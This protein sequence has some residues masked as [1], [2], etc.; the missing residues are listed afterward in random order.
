MNLSKIINEQTQGVT[1]FTV[2]SKKGVCEMGVSKHQ[3]LDKRMSVLHFDGKKWLIGVQV[4]SLLQRETYNLYRSLKIKGIY[5]KRATADQIEWLFKANVV[6]PGTRSVTF[7][8]FDPTLSFILEEAKKLSR[9][10]R[11][12]EASKKQQHLI[13]ESDGEDSPEIHR[14]PS[15]PIANSYTS[16]HHQGG[17]AGVIAGFPSIHESRPSLFPNNEESAQFN[18]LSILSAAA[19]TQSFSNKHQR[20]SFSSSFPTNNAFFSSPS[21]PPTSSS[22]PSS[23]SLWPQQQQP[24]QASSFER[25]QSM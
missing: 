5:V 14:I 6:R 9:K 22:L 21:S 18:S 4:A 10:K 13:S 24:S 2:T 7:V 1:S 16:Q 3:I 19:D 23:P 20:T 8:P 17:G 11:K 12:S 25:W 15:S